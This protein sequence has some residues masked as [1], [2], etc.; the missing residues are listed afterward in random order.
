MTLAWISRHFIRAFELFNQADSQ[1]SKGSG[2]GLKH[3][4]GRLLVFNEILKTVNPGFVAHADL[5]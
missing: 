5:I 1:R 3:G 4:D 2:L